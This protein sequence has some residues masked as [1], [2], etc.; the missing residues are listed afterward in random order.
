MTVAAIQRE[1][2]LTKR[3]LAEELRCSVRFIEYRLKDGLPS[4]M[5]AGRRQ[6]LLS[7]VE[8]WLRRNG[9]MRSG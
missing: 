8:P 1:R 3:E 5:F 2:P 9:H 7:E 4:E 6:F